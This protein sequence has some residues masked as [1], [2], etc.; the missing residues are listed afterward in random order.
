MTDDLE[1]FTHRFEQGSAAGSLPILLLH[2]TG[3][4]ENDLIDLGRVV[5]PGSA[6]L[7]PRGP[8]LEHGMP[9]FFRRLA[10]GVF[11]EA[12][13]KRRADEL[14][15]FVT[16]ARQHYA[17]EAPIALGFSNGANIAA[18]MLMQRPD[19]LSG[20]VLLRAMVP[21]VNPPAASIPGTPVLLVSGTQD[22]IAPTS[23]AAQLASQLRER[24][25]GVEHRIVPAGHGLT[26]A[27]VNLAAAFVKAA[28]KAPAL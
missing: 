22:P 5:A 4:D 25:A 24:G 19:V 6:L 11:D 14:A 23:N 16:A 20:A 21:L 15:G 13:V 27:D 18:A 9:R 12:D 7:S 8:V 26:Q 28:A 2:G 17:L 3:G 1:G 10:E